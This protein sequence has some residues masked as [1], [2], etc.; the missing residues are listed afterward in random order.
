MRTV[1]KEE[2][3]GESGPAQA[4]QPYWQVGEKGSRGPGRWF[5]TAVQG[6]EAGRLGLWVRSPVWSWLDL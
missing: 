6:P 4:E 1:G 5:L 2:G 3:G